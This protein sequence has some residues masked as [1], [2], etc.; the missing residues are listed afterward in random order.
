MMPDLKAAT[1]L[2]GVGRRRSLTG[3]RA[4]RAAVSD[5]S[6]A[7][8]TVGALALPLAGLVPG[9]V[10]GG[11][12][13]CEELVHTRG[14]AHRILPTAPKRVTAEAK[15]HAERSTLVR[16]LPGL[17][18]LSFLT[19]PAVSSLAFRAFDCEKFDGG[20]RFLRADYAVDCD[21]PAY[22]SIMS[23]AT[24]AILLYP[25]LIP[26]SYLLLLVRARRAISEERPTSLSRALSILHKSY[27]PRWY[28][29][30]LM[31]LWK[32]LFLVGFAAL[33]LPGTLMQAGK[34]LL[35]D[36]AAH[37]FPLPAGG[38]EGLCPKQPSLLL[39]LPIRLS[40]Q[41]ATPSKQPRLPF[42]CSSSSGLSSRSYSCWS[43][44]SWGPTASR[45]TTFSR[46]QFI[47]LSP[48][49][50]SCASSSRRAR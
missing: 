19:F 21:S 44:A 32:K 38:V 14:I 28:L 27:E 13:E 15:A 42:R 7:R 26:L 49:S 24:L 36:K 46:W 40:S 16:A 37:P 12:A 11:D 43:P 45:R 41:T 20:R 35:P 23:L 47:S 34:A 8:A 29:W 25:I 48:P 9:A 17:L 18:L 5:T 4:A 50:F 1:Q 39:Q 33:I 31:E 2:P 10:G 30:E 22:S 3:W 6:V